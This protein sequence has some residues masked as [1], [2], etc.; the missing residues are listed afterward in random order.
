MIQPR[1]Q[2][3]YEW[4]AAELDRS[5][6]CDL[7]RDGNPVYAWSYADRHVWAAQAGTWPRLLS[8]ATAPRS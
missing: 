1:L 2:R 4:S 5:E 3:L 6:L 7:V 8:R